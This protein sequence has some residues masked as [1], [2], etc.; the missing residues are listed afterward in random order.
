MDG[1]G[2]KKVEDRDVNGISG[3]T[4]YGKKGMRHGRIKTLEHCD[5]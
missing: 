3:K 4:R 1:N 5:G 2:C